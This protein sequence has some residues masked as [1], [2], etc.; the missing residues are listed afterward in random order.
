MI[1]N[2]IFDMGNVLV[3]YDPKSVCK[4]YFN[5][6]DV[7]QVL[8]VVFQSEQWLQLDEGT[9]SEE[10]AL[11][12]ML[13][14]LESR[15]HQQTIKMF[16]EWHYYL[17]PKKEMLEVVKRLASQGYHLYLL[18]NAGVRFEVFYQN[19]EAI[20]Y[21]EGMVISSRVQCNKP[22][23]KIYKILC[24][25]YRLNP[26]ECFFIDDYKENIDAANKLGIRGYVFDGNVDSLLRCMRSL[27]IEI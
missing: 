6:S 22:N 12:I 7:K 24:Q 26:G 3:T 17:K 19:I 18:S 14:R 23:A 5:E 10:A 13:S 1:Q 27:K 2:I 8:K 21:M 11:N 15:L 4:N 16:N 25:K 20:S 9:I